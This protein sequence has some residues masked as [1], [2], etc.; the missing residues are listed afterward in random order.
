MRSHN[1][2][3]SKFTTV[4]RFVGVVFVLGLFISSTAV[5]GSFTDD[6]TKFNA[7]AREMLNLEAEIHGL[8]EEKH[9]T[10]D[11]GKLKEI[12][13][14]IADRYREL[15]KL[16][17]EHDKLSVHIRFKYPEQ[18]DKIEGLRYSRSKLQTLEQ[19]ESEV[20]IDGRLDRVKA[21]V[22]A[23]FPAPEIE[24]PAP[25]EPKIHPFFRKPASVDE[26]A[27]EEIKLVK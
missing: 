7:Q 23:T 9:H 17:E 1:R 13:D 8:I 12:I 10:D 11:H 21:K 20:G 6:R 15:S 2:T 25:P 3:P 5:A 27:P 16:A 26:D 14:N 18:A 4:V 19:M 22:L 24:K